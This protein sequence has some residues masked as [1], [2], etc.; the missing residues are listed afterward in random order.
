MNLITQS[1]RINGSKGLSEASVA[2][3]NI[4]YEF[5][6][7]DLEASA[8]YMKAHMMDAELRKAEVSWDA[9]QYMTCEIQYGGRITDSFDRRLFNTYGMRWQTLR[10]ADSSFEFGDPERAPGYRIMKYGEIGRYRTEIETLKDDD[11]P[12][13]PL[14]HL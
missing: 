5:N 2:G 8:A 9:V 6:Q 10:I 12:E 11:H 7:S 14:L 1:H 4:P 13:A 3:W